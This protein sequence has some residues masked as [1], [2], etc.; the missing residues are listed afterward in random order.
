MRNIVNRMGTHNR[1][2][3][4]LHQISI[5]R[6]GSH[7]ERTKEILL[8]SEQPAASRNFLIES[9]I[10]SIVR[11]ACKNPTKPL[12]KNSIGNLCNNI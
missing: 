6:S 5:I 8:T 2:I 1:R 10:I 9:D 3:M 7:N 12:D 11:A 4:L